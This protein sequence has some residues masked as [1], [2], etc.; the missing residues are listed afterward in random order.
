MNSRGFLLFDID[1]VIRDVTRSYRL[2]IQ[3]TVNYFCNWKPE[4]ENIDNLKAEG[5]WN[6]DWEASYELIKRYVKKEERSI[7]LPKR[8]KL[9]KIF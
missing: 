4:L 7:V 5:I 1:G 9:I 8:Y 6:N 3:H 2:A